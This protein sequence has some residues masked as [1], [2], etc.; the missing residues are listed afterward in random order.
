M[1]GC[2]LSEFRARVGFLLVVPPFFGALSHPSVST[3]SRS[4]EMEPWSVGG[5]Y[6]RPVP[7]RLAEEQ[8]VAREAF[9]G[10]K[11]AV[12]V[13]LNRDGRMRHRLRP[14]SYAHFEQFYQEHRRLRN[15]LK[16]KAY[17]LMFG[18]FTQYRK[19]TGLIP[20]ASRLPCAVP[21][22]FREHPGR[23]SF[24]VHWAFPLVAQRYHGALTRIA[25]APPRAA[26]AVTDSRVAIGV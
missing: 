4:A 6:D 22:L 21:A 17:D 16:Q 1:C 18:L 12:A 20:G 25:S 3:I 9:G 7:R 11:N 19:L 10:R 23:P 14:D 8:G 26:M 13:L 2:S 5:R 15:P 24:L